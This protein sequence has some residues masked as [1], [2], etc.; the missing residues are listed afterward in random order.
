MVTGLPESE[1]YNAVAV[2]VDRLTKYCRFAPCRKEVTAVGYA[3]LFFD[4]V[5]RNF[6][7]PESIISDRDPRFMSLFWKE[8]FRL[9]GTKLKYST[10]H[11]PQTDGQ[12]EVTIRT[13]ENTLRPFVE[14]NPASWAGLISAAE[15]AV[16][17]ARNTSTQQTPF[18]LMMGQHPRT[19][20]PVEKESQIKSSQEMRTELDQAIQSARQNLLSAQERMRIAANKKRKDHEYSIGEKVW[21]STK[22]IPLKMFEHIPVKIRRKFVGPFRIIEKVSPVAYTLELPDQWRIHPTFHISRFKDYWT[23]EEFPREDFQPV[24]ELTEEG[25][26]LEY[27]IEEILNHHGRGRNRKFLIR[28]KGYAAHE[29]SWEPEK[30]LTN[31]A[32]VI[33][34]YFRKRGRT[35]DQRAR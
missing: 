34:E 11:H 30:M 8:L 31:C 27:E 26:P 7:L 21:L 13:L 9:S 29:D 19:L 22:H 32:E 33:K 18:F 2:F 10:A 15:F 1:G 20:E 5:F 4:H 16:N 24:G 6:G 23:S 12:S 3:R 35:S 28:W 25:E 14:E 17:N